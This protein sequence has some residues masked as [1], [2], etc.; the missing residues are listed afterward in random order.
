M[1]ERL[2]IDLR[3]NLSQLISLPTG[4][5]I[6]FMDVGMQGGTLWNPELLRELG[7][8]QVLIALLSAPYLNSPWCG[9]EWHAFSQRTAKR[10]PGA[11]AAN[12][13]GCII[14]VRWAPIESPLPTP[15]SD[16]MFFTPTTTPDPDLPEL[17]RMNGVFGLLRMRRDDYYQIVAWQLSMLIS[18]VYH[19]LHLEHRS[20][21]PGDLQNVFRGP[22][23]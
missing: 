9:M 2:Y 10:L 6:G 13:Q 19:A 1:T 7:S 11:K 16:D 18:R 20:F 14:P 3:V 23:S 21:E 17:Y 5:D 15:V 4:S 22:S 8:C 12:H